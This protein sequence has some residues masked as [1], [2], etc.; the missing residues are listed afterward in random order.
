MGKNRNLLKNSG[1]KLIFF[2]PKTTT[3][4][5]VKHLC[6]CDS[7]RQDYD[8][9][10]LFQNYDL[11][12]EN[13][14]KINLRSNYND[15]NINDGVERDEKTTSHNYFLLP[16]S[17]CV[18]A[19]DNKSTNTVWF[20]QIIRELDSPENVID[21]YGHTASAGQKYMLG[22]LLE[23]EHD[24]ITKT[25]YKLMYKKKTNFYRESI[26]YPFVNISEIN[27]HYIISSRDFVDIVNY[28]EHYAL[29][30]L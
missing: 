16:G 12:V 4:R 25:K 7:C 14:N 30:T 6:I 5:A 29:T 8:S 27:G 10:S 13:L 18:I 17:V 21:D 1:H 2:Y 20:V 28:V 11:V 22:Y 3:V 9:C 24:Q 23:Q 15:K 26:V 19:V